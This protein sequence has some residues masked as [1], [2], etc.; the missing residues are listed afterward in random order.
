M[1]KLAALAVPFVVVVVMLVNG[2]HGD[3]VMAGV[4]VLSL[5]VAG[6]ALGAIFGPGSGSRQE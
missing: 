4:L 6:V 2:L 3:R 5:A 1:W